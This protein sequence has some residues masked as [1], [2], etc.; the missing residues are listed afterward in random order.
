MW[1]REN[2]RL[3]K[4]LKGTEAETQPLDW[5]RRKCANRLYARFIWLFYKRLHRSSTSL[6]RIWASQG[7]SHILS[8]FVNEEQTNAGSSCNL[9]AIHSGLVHDVTDTAGHKMAAL[10][11]FAFGDFQ[12]WIFNQRD[13]QSNENCC[14]FIYCSILIYRANNVASVLLPFD[15]YYWVKAMAHTHTHS[16]SHTHTRAH[17]QL[18]A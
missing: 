9:H 16:L 5:K 18:F 10:S 3:E 6:L 11:V 12:T 7:C 4:M 17:T 15:F 1:I 2:L 8:L 14:V 13:E